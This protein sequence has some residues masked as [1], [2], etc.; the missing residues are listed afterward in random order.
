MAKYAFAYLAVMLMAGVI[1]LAYLSSNNQM[2]FVDR[3]FEGGDVVGPPPD[4]AP[5]PAVPDLGLFVADANGST[6]LGPVSYC[7][8][9]GNMSECADGIVEPATAP[10][11]VSTAAQPIELVFPLDWEVSIEITPE[12]GSCQPHVSALGMTTAATLDELGPVGTYQL[13]VFS[14]GPQGDASWFFRVDNQSELPLPDG[15]SC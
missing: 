3:G 13:M 4:A 11:F 7:Y 2:V 15:V 14:S 5:E 6:S 9:T 10:L 8:S 1:G 12:D